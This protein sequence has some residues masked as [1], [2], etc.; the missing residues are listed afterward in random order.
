[1]VSWFAKNEAVAQTMKIPWNFLKFT[2]MYQWLLRVLMLLYEDL[3]NLLITNVINEYNT[4]H[5][6]LLY[7]CAVR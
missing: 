5:D 3:I 6:D 2:T 4:D 7:D 1:M